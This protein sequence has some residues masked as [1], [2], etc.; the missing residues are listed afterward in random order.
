MLIK[1]DNYFIE[2]KKLVIM[3][4]ISNKIRKKK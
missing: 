4:Y 1:I 3:H 2:K